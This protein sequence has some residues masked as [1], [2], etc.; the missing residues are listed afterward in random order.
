MVVAAQRRRSWLLVA[1]VVLG[2][3]A[4]AACQDPSPG[5]PV[6]PV[7]PPDAG[8]GRTEIPLDGWLLQS[9]QQV[10]DADEAIASPAY[11]PRGWHPAPVPGTVVGALVADGTYPDPYVGMNLRSLPGARDYDIGEEFYHV[12]MSPTNPHRVAWWYR[13]EFE[14]PPQPPGRRLWLRLGGVNYRAAV[15]LNGQRLADDRQ[16]VG[17]FRSFLF[18]VTDQA[19]TTAGGRN[20]VA[21]KVSAPELDDLAINWVDW[22][23]FPPDKNQG[24]WRPVDLF[25][26][27]A[28]ALDAPHVVTDVELPSLA[29][30]RLTVTVEARNPTDRPVRARIEARIEAIR[31]AHGEPGPLPPALAVA[32]DV[33]LAAGEVR[34]VRFEPGRFPALV[35][36]QP[37][38]WW[39]FELGAQNLYALTAR[40]TV[41]GV[42][43]DQVATRFGIREVSSE[44]TDAGHRVFLVNGHRVLVR[45]A[46]WTPDL[47]LRPEPARVDDQLAYVKDMRLDV[48]RLEGK[49]GDPHLLDRCDEEGILVMAGWCCCDQW[50]EPEQWDAEDHA[51]ALA[52]LEEQARLL[53]THP[54]LLVW[55]NGSDKTATTETERG[56]MAALRKLDWPAPVIASAG[57]H[58]SEVTGRTGVK[59]NGPY[60]WV[61]PNYWA[62]DRKRG[63]AFGFNTETSAGA[64]IP[65]VESL[66][67][68]LPADHLWPVDEVWRFHAGG[69]KTTQNL[70]TYMAALDARYG[71]SKTVDEFAFKS[72]LATYE[73]V[74]AMFEAFGRNKYRATGVVQWMLNDPW[75]G[76]IWHLYDW[77]LKPGGGYFGAKK[78]GEPLHVQYGYDDRA[79]VVVNATRAAH[80]G[81]VVRAQV[82]DLDGRSRWSGDATVDVG[83]DGTVTALTVPDPAT[84]A[85]LDQ[86]F[87]VQLRLSS[88]A[89][90]VVS[91]NLYWLSRK[92]DV[93]DWAHATWFHTP[94]IAYAD[95]T[96]LGRL[97]PASIA[98]TATRR[99]VGDDDEIHVVL[100]HRGGPLAFF[101]RAEV[102]RRPDGDE[103][104]PVRWSDN[105]V[106]L[107]P[108]EA[109]ELVARYPA[110]AI[111]GGGLLVRVVGGNVAAVRAAVGE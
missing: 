69:S 55:L 58:Q 73:G 99:R 104:V 90:V 27:G 50:E 102:A 62:L 2:A 13:T 52:S 3:T 63:G 110:K 5:R 35:V 47:L 38:L 12:P 74:R 65:P 45:G 108:G 53:R 80:R 32:T 23:P 49:L 98:V 60:L 48:V 18:D 20:V 82:L 107:V 86:T 97:G 59:M 67:K 91:D 66:R 7:P 57:D 78:A 68:F 14:V 31:S 56:Y 26:T 4:A 95:L 10:S 88:A 105:Y 106:T 79:V 44:L 111:A 64:A 84:L 22:A 109:R 94:T 34:V 19:N 30:A 33:E 76:L 85:G 89:G 39:P 1:A 28:V 93:L 8:P 16:V 75:P 92:P 72:Q 37:R 21:L 70:D 36:V 101:L 100:Q 25:A 9:S 51:V 24:L 81:L 43:S 87:F 54:S 83:D 77:Y 46:G 42:A 40:A 103:L 11:A 96:G 29:R 6:P 17:A 61:P 71:R 41:D 15:W